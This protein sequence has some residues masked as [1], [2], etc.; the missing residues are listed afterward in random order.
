MKL[1]FTDTETTGLDD[2]RHD[3]WEVALIT[4]TDSEPD[5]GT[6]KV[7]E[8]VWQLPVNLTEA[9]PIALN[10][11]RFHD[12]RLPGVD[13]YVAGT[14][15]DMDIDGWKRRT[16]QALEGSTEEKSYVV[17]EGWMRQ[18]S[19]QF[20]ELTRDAFLVGNVISFDEERL[21][22]LLRL[23]DQTPMWNYHL[24]DVEA[25]VAGKLG[26]QPPWRGSTVAEAIGCPAPADQHSA[27]ADARWA[28]EIYNA[29]YKDPFTGNVRRG[30]ISSDDGDKLLIT[31]DSD[32]GEFQ[33]GERVAV[34]PLHRDL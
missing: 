8:F 28:R 3:I 18:W 10:I 2:R 23:H 5:D 16:E 24:I 15:D 1:A 31:L 13:H 11:G 6:Q 32:K 30:R 14:P 12:R 21:R 34:A 22:K 29:V 19:A 9:D 7:E 33:L 27:L 17:P 26:M 4:V 25:L 20:V